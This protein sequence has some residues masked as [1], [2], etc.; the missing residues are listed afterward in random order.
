MDDAKEKGY[1]LIVVGERDIAVLDPI[2]NVDRIFRQELAVKNMELSI[3]VDKVLQQRILQMTPFFDADYERELMSRLP[4]CTSGRWHPEFT[5]ITGALADKGQGVL[6]MAAHIGLDVSHTLAFG[7]GG[8]DL[9]MIRTAGIGIAMGNAIDVLKA[10][11][12]YITT[13]VDDD[14]IRNALKHFELI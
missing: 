11:A 1:G 6:A 14:G 4:H 3:P 10:D 8:N 9:S 13:S 7:D 12:D 5:D 2:G